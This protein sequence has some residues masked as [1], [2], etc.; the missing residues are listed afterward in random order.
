MDEDAK[1]KLDNLLERIGKSFQAE[2]I[3]KRKQEDQL[4]IVTKNS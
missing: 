2:E 4:K 1:A 3:A